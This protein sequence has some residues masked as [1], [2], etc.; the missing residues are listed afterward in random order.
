MTEDIVRRINSEF[1]VHNKQEVIQKVEE[2]STI[3]YNVGFDL[4]IDS[5]L[6]LSDGDISK[7]RRYFPIADPRDIV[8]EAQSKFG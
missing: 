3:S 6:K 4:L 2:M 1:A 5:L 7:F 8:H